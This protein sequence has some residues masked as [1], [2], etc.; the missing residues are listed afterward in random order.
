MGVINNSIKSIGK[1]GLQKERAKSLLGGKDR[2]EGLQ[3]LAEETSLSK[4]LNLIEEYNL[5]PGRAADI[6]NNRNTDLASTAP[7]AQGGAN[8]SDLR[9]SLLEKTKKDSQQEDDAAVQQLRTAQ[10]VAAMDGTAETEDADG[11][12]PTLD[13][14]NFR[15]FKPNAK[16]ENAFNYERSDKEKAFDLLAE[17][18]LLK[19]FKELLD[20][21]NF[22]DLMNNDEFVDRLRNNDPAAREMLETIKSDP[23]KFDEVMK[24]N[25]FDKDNYE[26]FSG[27]ESTGMQNVVKAGLDD[28][29]YK[30]LN[31]F[32]NST[33]NTGVNSAL[34]ETL[35]DEALSNPKLK[36]ILENTEMGG[37]EKLQAI[38][39]ESAKFV[40]E[41]MQAFGLTEDKEGVL[42]T[43]E[44]GK[45]NLY[46]F[47]DAAAKEKLADGLLDK[48]KE[49]HDNRNVI[50]IQTH[51]VDGNKLSNA[52]N[53]ARGF[54][55]TLD[56]LREGDMSVAVVNNTGYDP[57]S[58][59]NKLI[60]STDGSDL[61]D[62]L[63]QIKNESQSDEDWGNAVPKNEAY[64]R[65]KAIDVDKYEGLSIDSTGEKA[66][67]FADQYAELVIKDILEGKDKTLE[68]SLEVSSDSLAAIADGIDIKLDKVEKSG[69]KMSNDFQDAIGKFAGMDDAKVSELS[70]ELGSFGTKKAGMLLQVGK[71][72]KADLTDND[73]YLLDLYDKFENIQ[74]KNTKD[75]YESTLDDLQGRG[76]VVDYLDEE[77]K[78]GQ[79]YREVAEDIMNMPG[80]EARAF[81]DGATA[82]NMIGSVNTIAQIL[83]DGDR[84][85][86]NGEG[87]YGRLTIADSK[88]HN[89]AF[90][91]NTG[92]RYVRGNEEAVMSLMSGG[93]I[94]NITLYA[95]DGRNGKAIDD[96]EFT[97][98]MNR[99]MRKGTEYQSNGNL[100]NTNDG[101]E[102]RGLGLKHMSEEGH[103]NTRGN[104]GIVG[105]MDSGDK[106]RFATY[107]SLVKGDSF[108][109]NC[110][111]CSN[112]GGGDSYGK[113]VL[114]GMSQHLGK[115]V[116]LY[117]TGAEV[118]TP[119][120]DDGA[121]V[122]GGH[123]APWLKTNSDRLVMAQ[124][125]QDIDAQTKM[126]LN[127]V[128]HDEYGITRMK[129]G[130]TQEDVTAALETQAS[131]LLTAASER[132]EA[133]KF[134][135]EES[136]G[137]VIRTTDDADTNW[138]AFATNADDASGE[139]DLALASYDAGET[140]EEQ[141]SADPEPETDKKED[142]D[143]D[144][145][146]V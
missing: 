83:H 92:N 120:R 138:D 32:A 89:G 123:F 17:L 103:G 118:P 12:G 33:A 125:K 81:F 108:S 14:T 16:K 6:V 76:I 110:V 78:D 53:L 122:F 100:A 72:D 131:G 113:N 143:K 20:N 59:S 41:N 79:T 66:D 21:D 124:G 62:T 9:T 8:I 129:D 65:L 95:G 18:G 64:E 2:E 25:N 130:V 106:D 47:G 71:T 133:S 67:G 94:G 56:D 37:R 144:A 128:Y 7:G 93:K 119:P 115:H 116:R 52:E 98:R 1:E 61:V 38:Q 13:A 80:G 40:K 23:F 48:I 36:E 39:K 111:A 86:E 26:V 29:S 87:F 55:V 117:G 63:E 15:N 58:P 50:F 141:A 85:F 74:G 46:I 57:M 68:D 19:D 82:L 28:E 136:N 4:I 140:A 75:L 121:S 127:N 101:G 54:D 91:L 27:M 77:F 109:L 105:S 24:Q 132:S 11:D 70:S 102:V 3:K 35:V 134:N 145:F 49:G 90:G 114:E 99:L 5:D 73:Q 96:D 45:E 22:I 42:R 112:M 142:T 34:M 107:A 30:A 69:F 135:I 44:A 43:T 84:A 146:V 60:D 97:K 139:S 126:H 104:H 88:D 31:D 10:L 137:D 51:D